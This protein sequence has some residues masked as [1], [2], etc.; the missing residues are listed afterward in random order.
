VPEKEL[1]VA[2]G[3]AARS[4]PPSVSDF[5][6]HNGGN[7]VNQE[8]LII[9]KEKKYV[10]ML[11]SLS[12]SGLDLPLPASGTRRIFFQIPLSWN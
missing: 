11:C 1:V 3:P 8:T 4:E 7:R 5:K 9:L 2:F 6:F 12:R 10:L